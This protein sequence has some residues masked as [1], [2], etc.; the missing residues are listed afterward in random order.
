V[1]GFTF[2]RRNLFERRG[3]TALLIIS[4]AIAFLIFGLLNGFMSLT[5]A[6]EDPT[7]QS[8]LMVVNRTGIL[9]GLPVSYADQLR[10]VEGVRG[11]TSVRLFGAYGND[12]QDNLPLMMVDAPNYLEVNPHV[13]LSAE[14]REAF[15]ATRDGVVVDEATAAERGWSVGERITVRSL[16]FRDREGS[17]A[18][19][20]TLVGTFPSEGEEGPQNGMIGHLSY[21]DNGLAVGG[22][23]V[24]WFTVVTANPQASEAVAQRIDARFANSANESRTQSEAAMAQAFLGQL[25]D[26]SAIVT[27]VVGAAFLALI[28]AVGNS[29]ALT[30]RQRS[31]QIGVLKVLGFT[32]ARVLRFTLAETLLLAGTGAA[33]GLGLAALLLTLALTGMR[34]PVPSFGLPTATLLQ[35]IGL[36]LLLGIGTG[37]LPALR[38]MR[39]SP[40]TAF[41]RE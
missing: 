36:A 5:T 39:V 33:I 17:D 25:G 16:F 28:F 7:A 14:Q 22:G 2:I 30:V 3:R 12:R 1:T 31:R 6:F 11:V 35:G 27:L 20:F 41:G 19:S 21:L 37:L 32:P 18:W 9:R 15:L 8:R 26:L 24:N 23:L 38:A 13:T 10:Q 4:T 34:M 40:A 29:I